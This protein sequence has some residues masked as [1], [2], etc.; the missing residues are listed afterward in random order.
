[1]DMTEFCRSLASRA[2]TVE[3]RR[4][5]FR[6][7]VR[8]PRYRGAVHLAA[9]LSTCVGCAALALLAV[10]S[11][12]ALEYWAI[13][14]EL[15][16]S[17]VV[18]YFGHRYPMHRPVRGLQWV[19]DLH[20]RFHHMVFSASETELDSIDDICM[21]MFPVRDILGMCVV[22]VPLLSVPWLLLGGLDPALAFAATGHLFY[23]SYELIHLAAHGRVGGPLDSVPGLGFLLRHH[24]RHHAWSVMHQRNFS[25]I[26]V[27]WDWLM[28]T[29]DRRR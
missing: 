1:M 23:L 22:V 7:E 5:L 11:W 18:V 25:M 8:S 13:A 28:G 24:R 14:S 3:G 20:T 4:A 16:L 26:F 21:V 29:L 10:D 12:G 15:L 6:R 2:S 19:Y 9:L 17:S 27:G